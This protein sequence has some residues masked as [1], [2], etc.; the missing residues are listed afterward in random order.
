MHGYEIT[1]NVKQPDPIDPLSVPTYLGTY[2]SMYPG[3]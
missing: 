3:R 1:E 2:L